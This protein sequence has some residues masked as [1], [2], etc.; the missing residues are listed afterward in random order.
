M[1]FKVVCLF[2]GSLSIFEF[3]I[4]KRLDDKLIQNSDEIYLEVSIKI[5][6]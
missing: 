5:N 6:K 4:K 1:I 2:K 3:R